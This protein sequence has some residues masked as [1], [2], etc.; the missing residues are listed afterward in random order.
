MSIQRT[1]R[2]RL[3][4]AVHRRCRQSVFRIRFNVPTR[5]KKDTNQSYYRRTAIDYSCC[6][7]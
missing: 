1:S 3:L 5:T 4:S 6:L 7:F 2:N